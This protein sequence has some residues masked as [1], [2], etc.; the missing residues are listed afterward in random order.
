VLGSFK[1]PKQP[2][3]PSGKTIAVKILK[4]ASME[5]L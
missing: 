5:D 4:G 1:D 2:E 3:N